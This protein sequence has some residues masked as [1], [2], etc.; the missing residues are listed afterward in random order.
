MLLTTADR[1]ELPA[2]RLVRC[3][4]T[5]PGPPGGAR[6]IDVVA[7]APP[8]FN[9]VNHALAAGATGGWLCLT[10]TLPEPL[11]RPSFAAACAALMA[12]HEVLRTTT[13]FRDGAPVTLSFGDEFDWEIVE[14]DCEGPLADRRRQLRTLVDDATHTVDGPKICF[15]A[16]DTGERSTVVIAL[17]H[18]LTDAVSMAVLGRDVVQLY[19]AARDHDRAVLPPVGSF[20]DACRAEAATGGPD[21]A[22]AAAAG[23]DLAA[24]TAGEGFADWHAFFDRN[25]GGLPRFPLPDAA[26]AGSGP[27]AIDLRTVLTA[28]RTATLDRFARDRGA[29]LPACLLA[30][31]A[32]AAHAQGLADE[33]GTLLPV[34]TRSRDEWREAVGWFVSNG[35]VEL[36]A[37]EPL[38]RLLVR[39]QQQVERAQRLATLPLSDV[40]A[41]YARGFAHEGDVGMISYVDYRRVPG[42]ELHERHAVTQ[43]SPDAPTTDVQLWWVRDDSGLA[44]RARLPDTAQAR[45]IVGGWLDEVERTLRALT[46]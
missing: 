6:V 8:S 46:E 17:D 30:V 2:G 42:H 33:F 25:Q 34:G 37:G 3:I 12:R 43:A 11:D 14:S 32:S 36:A 20:L 41:S 29:R 15:A 24:E 7:D 19:A 27:A 23:P 39:A 45:S 18:G 28:D 44:L 38:D 13:S 40:L 5:P 26:R 22:A 31:C 35:P 16:I 21:A 1:L 9:Q 10:L 4:P